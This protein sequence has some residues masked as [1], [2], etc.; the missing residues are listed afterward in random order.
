MAIGEIKIWRNWKYLVHV[1]GSEAV[2]KRVD[3]KLKNVEI[4]P[5]FY[6]EQVTIFHARLYYL[7]I[8]LQLQDIYGWAV[9]DKMLQ[10]FSLIT[11]NYDNTLVKIIMKKNNNFDLTLYLENDQ[12]NHR[13]IGRQIWIKF[14]KPLSFICKLKTHMELTNE[15]SICRVCRIRVEKEK[16]KQLLNHSIKKYPELAFNPRSR[17]QTITQKNYFSKTANK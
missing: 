12:I 5:F 14:V 7:L 8:D 13:E 16:E 1:V 15:N 2:Y 17:S 9:T 4:D 6:R 11:Q 3:Q 10:L